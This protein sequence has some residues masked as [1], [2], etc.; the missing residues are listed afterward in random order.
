MPAATA[1]DSDV[2]QSAEHQQGLFIANFDKHGV[3]LIGPI[4]SPVFI[5]AV[6]ALSRRCAPPW[7]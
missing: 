6:I 2:T 3:N 4:K 5:A 1:G 7:E